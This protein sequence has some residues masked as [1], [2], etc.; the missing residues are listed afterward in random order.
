MT[1]E[2]MCENYPSYYEKSL[3]GRCNIDFKVPKQ[4]F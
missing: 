1:Y 2:D 3:K 4:W